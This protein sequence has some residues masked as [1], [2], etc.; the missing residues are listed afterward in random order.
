MKIPAF[1]S[2]I[3]S[4]PKKQGSL[5]STITRTLLLF[6]FIPLT[7]M[8]G[9]AYYR[10]RTLLQ[11]QIVGQMQSLVT[12]QTGET[13]DTIK[14]RQIRLDHIIRQPKFSSAMQVVLQQTPGDPLFTEARNTLIVTF[15]EINREEANPLFNLFLILDAD[16]NVL[17]SSDRNWEGATLVDSPNY[18]RL[19]DAD[20][21][22]FGVYDFTPFYPGKFSLLTVGQYRTSD[23]V[24]RATIIGVSEQ[25]SAA[26]ILQSLVNRVPESGAYFVSNLG[27]TIG[28]DPYTGGLQILVTSAEQ[29]ETL[30][31]TFAPMME[32]EVDI[33]PVTVN[34]SN[35][36]GEPVISQAVWLKELHTGIVLEVPTESIFGNLNDLILFTFII[37][38]FAA[39]AMFLVISAGTNR[40]IEPILSLSEITGRFA[41]G[42]WQ[43]RASV[44][45]NDE[46]G[47]LASSFNR[48]ADQISSMYQSL[49]EQVEERTRQ[50]R[51]A[52]E[53]AQGLTTAFNLDELLQKTVQ[54]IVDRF[55]FYH[56][57]I[58]MLDA[59]GKYASLRAAHGPSAEEMLKRG[60]QLQ[61]GSASIVGWVSANLKP[62]RSN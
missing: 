19:H 12:T 54:L 35:E 41:Q 52:A 11:D 59:S 53:V 55:G 28:L 29:K 30:A 17:A 45:S 49:Q 7:L 26:A 60:H 15:N 31:Q 34:Y 13:R 61:V 20:N 43:E 56:A 3:F 39:I 51:T 37:F 1:L 62:R 42:N 22:S 57:G 50:I 38:V 18:A 8:A 21:E 14:I 32:A 5:A 48:M 40:L 58:F 23:G 33:T 6:T 24:A 47:L 4:N 27:D 16:G 46:V 36:K 2:H 25:Q 10:A 44:R 9:V